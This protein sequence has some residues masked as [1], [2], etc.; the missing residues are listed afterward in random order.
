MQCGARN[1]D[2]AGMNPVL[3]ARTSVGALVTALVATPALA[4]TG[5]A[6]GPALLWAGLAVVVVSGVVALG[7]LF[8]ATRTT[9]RA[10]FYWALSGAVGLIA[11]FIYFGTAA[12]EPTAIP[13]AGGALVL[14]GLVALV[15]S[16]AAASP[17]TS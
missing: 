5:L 13:L 3:V 9:G 1:A 6:D 14:Y 7:A 8:S 2:D 15:V 16:V 11:G 17:R 12:D 10:P 4:A